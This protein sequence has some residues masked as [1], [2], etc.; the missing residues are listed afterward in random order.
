MFCCIIDMTYLLCAR[1]IDIRMMK[2]AQIE[3]GYIRIKPGKTKGTSGLAVD[4]LI[5][6]AIQAVIDRARAIKRRYKVIC[7][8]LFPTTDG[9]PYTKSGLTSM[10]ERARERAKPP[11]I[12]FKDIRALA[13]TDAAKAGR[14]KEEIRARLVHTD[15]KTSEIYIK[16][17][18]PE[19]SELELNLPWESM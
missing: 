18:V 10:W 17:T 13:A 11:H 6:P 14:N 7:P 5:T 9:T 15:S 12:Q 2:E 19:K 16:E 3:A 1:A 4:I 8:Y